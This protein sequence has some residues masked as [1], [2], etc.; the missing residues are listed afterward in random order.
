MW[1]NEQS[2][3]LARGLLAVFVFVGAGFFLFGASFSVLAGD[4]PNG[5][6]T[7]LFTEIVGIGVTIAVVNWF[8]RQRETARRKKVLVRR[9]GG[10]SNEFAKDAVSEMRT[11]GWLTG[12]D[13][14]LQGIDLSGANLQGAKLEGANLK[15]A[16][17]YDAN[18]RKADLRKAN[19]KNTRLTG[20][21]L[22]EAELSGAT[23]TGVDLQGMNL[24]NIE[25][26]DANLENTDLRR[27]NL[28]G[29]KLYGAILNGADL[30]EARLIGVEFGRG[31]NGMATTADTKTIMPNGD[32]Y[33]TD[34]GLEQFDKFTNKKFEAF[35]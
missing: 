23:L 10:A 30:R 32:R 6:W 19:L 25:L 8:A 35:Y 17:L 14:L 18:L 5:Y 21:K 22:S 34:K 7:N 2:G 20:A 9:A 27:A 11:E 16:I 33:D 28:K 15:C 29:A 26:Y 12:E 4:D 1:G 13:G 24:E 31:P 3:A